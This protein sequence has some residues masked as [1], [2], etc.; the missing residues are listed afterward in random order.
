MALRKG[1]AIVLGLAGLVYFAQGTGLFTAVDSIM[2]NNI[3][4]AIIGIV[5]VVAGL[6]IWPRGNGKGG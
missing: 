1:L 3:T 4:W 2:N 6:L 5:M